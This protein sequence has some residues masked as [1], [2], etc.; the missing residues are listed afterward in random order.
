M[1]ELVAFLAWNFET[2]EAESL[3]RDNRLLA[4]AAENGE[5]GF[6]G[7]LPQRSLL[8]PVGQ[9]VSQSFQV[10]VGFL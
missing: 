2:H 6:H 3:S 10:F 4:L 5:S 7:S 9:L 1:E 8:F